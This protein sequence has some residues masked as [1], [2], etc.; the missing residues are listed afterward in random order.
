MV[1]VNEATSAAK[2]S[3][4]LMCPKCNRGRIGSVPGWSKT[5]ISRRGK[6]P[7]EE[8]R[9]CIFIRCIICGAYVPIT[10]E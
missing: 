3:K 2:G 1:V 8:H 10:I 4:P 6:P 5:E 7:P 9:E